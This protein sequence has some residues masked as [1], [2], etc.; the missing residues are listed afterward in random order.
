[1]IICIYII[2][3][4]ESWDVIAS[5]KCVPS[6]LGAGHAME[7]IALGMKVFS[8]WIYSGDDDPGDYGN[9]FL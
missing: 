4:I 1:M 5:Y 7:L 9:Y 8:F 2:W 6:P 3:L